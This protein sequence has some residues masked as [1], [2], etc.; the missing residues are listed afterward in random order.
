MVTNIFRRF[1]YI[2]F[3]AGKNDIEIMSTVTF[4]TLKLSRKLEKAGF[5]R[6]QAAGAAEALAEA[7]ADHALTRSE[8]REELHPLHN[9][10]SIVKAE[11]AMVKWMVGGTFF[12]VAML[13]IRS[14]WPG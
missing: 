10:I 3:W 6:E 9:E 5:T 8:L 14:L 2:D 13:V 7:M 11:L 1:G 4:D 12:G